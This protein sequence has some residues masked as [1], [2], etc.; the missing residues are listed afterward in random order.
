VVSGCLLFPTAAQAVPVTAVTASGSVHALAA[1][2]ATTP[3]P[4][5]PSA[6]GT[7]TPGATPAAGKTSTPA[8]TPTAT[9]APAAPK[10]PAATSTPKAQATAQADATVQAAT[11]KTWAIYRN[12][13]SP[14]IYE[15]VNGTTPTP[16]SK[17]RWLS[18]YGGKTPLKTPTDYVRYSWSPSLYA[19]TY[20]PGGETAR[21]WDRL[22]REQVRAVGSPTGR[23]VGFIKGT[24]FYRW[25]TSDQII[26][27]APDG[28]RHVMTAQEWKDAGNRRVEN[29]I[30]NGFRKLP[31][32]ADIVR[33]T[34]IA[35]G[36]GHPVTAAVWAAEGSPSPEVV[37]SAPGELFSRAAGDPTIWYTGLTIDRPISNAEWVAAGKP[38]PTVRQPIKAT[39]ISET[40]PTGRVDQIVSGPAMTSVRGWAFDPDTT[41][42]I[43]VDIYVDGAWA[44]TAKAD[45]LR[46]DVAEA[47]P[48]AGSTHGFTADIATTPGDH[49]VCAY[50]INT[51]PGV[52]VKISCS[53]DPAPG[54]PKVNPA[55]YSRT[56]ATF[57]NNASAAIQWPFL[58]GVPL[59][60]RFGPRPVVCSVC[61]PVHNGLDFT[62]GSGS[63]IA[64]I[65]EGRVSAVVRSSAKTGFGTYVVIDHK[66]DGKKV[67]SVYAHLL[68]D[69]PIFAVGD[70]VRQ[71]DRVGRVG[72]TGSSTGAHLHLEIVVNGVR[73]DPY[74]WLTDHNR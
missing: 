52:H 11:G 71:G 59:S 28:V 21:Q 41:D 30:N 10:A 55:T 54:F 62:P 56:A 63:D 51:G 48:K 25:S 13:Y 17:E 3:V 33:F 18:V 31:W 16:L 47:Y 65:A 46:S 6:T 14:T 36:R 1:A 69:S 24:I 60:D 66:I 29:R 57:T 42:P 2:G 38:D 20:W 58:R 40:S 34:D 67:Q 39:A 53:N 19:V 45:L 73:V 32:A 7:P 61:L 23:E 12:A 68:V 64:A 43:L 27:K 49:N 35:G 44:A 70:Y 72:T 4:A 5:T 74:A 50:A 26:A 9:P 37:S 22:T 8:P 15:L